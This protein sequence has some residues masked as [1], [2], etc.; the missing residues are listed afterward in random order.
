MYQ[1]SK[2][3]ETTTVPLVTGVMSLC[4]TT[5][6]VS[7]WADFER[8]DKQR[9]PYPRS[10]SLADQP[11]MDLGSVETH[12]CRAFLSD[13]KSRF[14]LRERGSEGAS[15]TVI[16]LRVR[17]R[18]KQSLS[19]HGI[20]ESY[21]NFSATPIILAVDIKLAIAVHQPLAN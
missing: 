14:A 16:C 1:S 3:V 20:T 5:T 19:R 15:G 11:R 2:E 18:H 8:L 4:E 10:H 9:I 12:I 6:F 21:R 7:P 17:V 13:R